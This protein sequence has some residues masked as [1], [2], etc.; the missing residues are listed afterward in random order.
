MFLGTELTD[1]INSIVN[2]TTYSSS[3]K[4]EM[5]LGVDILPNFPMDATDRNRTSPFAFT[6]NKFEFRML[7]S[8]F[9]IAGPN[10]VL[11][12]IVAEARITSYNVCYTKLLRYQQRLFHTYHL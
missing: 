9:S 5:T 6:G 12:T 10:V 4:T 8:T 11:N 2:G 3:A 7:G 1:I